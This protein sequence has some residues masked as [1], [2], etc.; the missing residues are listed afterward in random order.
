MLAN[1]NQRNL[2]TI[3]LFYSLAL[4]AFLIGWG[5]GL[6]IREF[7]KS[8]CYLVGYGAFGLALLIGLGVVYVNTYNLNQ[9]FENIP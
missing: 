3:I 2:N 1:A 9:F 4:V 6:L 5:F 7:R 8:H